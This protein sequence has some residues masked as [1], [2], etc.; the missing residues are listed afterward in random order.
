VP[1]LAGD[2]PPRTKI[3]VNL[4]EEATRIVRDLAASRGAT[5][6]D[7][8]REALAV[9][10]FLSEELE[11]KNTYLELVKRQGDRE[12]RQRVHFVFAR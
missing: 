4:S 9:Y 6:S 11:D 10:R 8:I 12:D 5:T 7:V 3:S 1:T 2:A